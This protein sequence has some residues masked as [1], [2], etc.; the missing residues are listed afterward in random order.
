MG[1]TLIV[2]GVGVDTMEW[3]SDVKGECSKVV[4]GVVLERPVKREMKLSLT[5]KQEIKI[6]E[7]ASTFSPS[8]TREDM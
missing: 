2:K 3:Y 8:K 4:C 5:K 6:N 7:G 1:S